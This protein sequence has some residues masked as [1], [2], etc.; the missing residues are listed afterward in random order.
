MVEQFA[1]VYRTVQVL[2]TLIYQAGVLGVLTVKRSLTQWTFGSFKYSSLQTWCIMY[3]N[4]EIK[5]RVLKTLYRE[6]MI[7]LFAYEMGLYYILKKILQ[8]D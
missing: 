8:T 5:K 7:V 3:E 1:C 6:K 2:A 4:T